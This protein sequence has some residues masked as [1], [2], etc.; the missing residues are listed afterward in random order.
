MSGSVATP[1]V[2]SAVSASGEIDSLL[3]EKF[4]GMVH[5]QYLKGENLI[6]YFDMQQV[7]GT[8]M[9]SNK[10]IGETSLQTLIPGQE[11]EGSSVEYDKN[12]L[13]IDTQVIARNIVAQFHDVQSDINSNKSKLAKNQVKQLKQLEDE[14]IIQQILYG[15]ISNTQTVRTKPRVAGHGFSIKVV[16]SD[17]QAADPD[18]LLAAIEYAME[19]QLEQEVEITDV[20]TMLPWKYFN[21]LS[22]AERLINKD[23]TTAS[24]VKMS[25]YVLKGNN[26]PVVPSNRFPRVAHTG[27][28]HSLLSAASN[29]FRYDNT[30]EM[31]N[32][33]AVCF[34]PDAL[35]V[36]QTLA[37]QGDIFW[38]KKTKSYF[39]D[40]WYAQGAIPD[41]WEA[42]SAVFRGG[43]ENAEVKARAVRKAKRT[44]TVT[45]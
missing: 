11:P 1:L 28:N 7:Q 37:L 38:D 40:S 30:A 39:I 43:S 5:E 45:P 16:I 20:V 8:N 2:N 25:G 14:M 12:A 18:S 21:T 15:V 3:I 23:Y 6:A 13:V 22:D 44:L 35:L 19:Q 32:A 33:V 17:A 26:V 41:R 10:Y 42:A 9:V 24:D 27:A 31:L 34:A 29:G 4:N 36:G